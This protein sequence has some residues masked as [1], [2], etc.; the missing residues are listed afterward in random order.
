MSS[1]NSVTDAPHENQRKKKEK[2]N[3]WTLAL[4][5]QSKVVLG[6]AKVTVPTVLVYVSLFITVT[7][8]HPLSKSG[9]FPSSPFHN[10]IWML[11][12]QS[13]AIY[14]L[15]IIIVYIVIFFFGPY[16]VDQ[17]T[18]ASLDSS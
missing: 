13:P 7:L 5:S 6:G 18:S 4:T 8:F 10:Q 2:K 14:R 16:L 15:F 17:P 9:V 11:G 12:Q 1:L 3:S